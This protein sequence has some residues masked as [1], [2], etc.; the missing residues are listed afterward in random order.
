MDNLNL[1]AT[2]LKGLPFFI[3]TLYYSYKNHIELLKGGL[4][5]D[6][7]NTFICY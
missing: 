6:I 7:V 5:D 3:Y 4:G 1:N 2:F